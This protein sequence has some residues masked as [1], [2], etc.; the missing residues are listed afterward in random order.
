MF[1]WRLTVHRR[2]LKMKAKN[3][4][5]P[6][7]KCFFSRSFCNWMSLSSTSLMCSDSH[8]IWN[9]LSNCAKFRNKKKGNGAVIEQKKCV[10]HWKLNATIAKEYFF[11]DFDTILSIHLSHPHVLKIIFVLVCRSI[12]HLCVREQSERPDCILS[13]GNFYYYEF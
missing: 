4:D 7:L 8:R 6:P 9:M 13:T 12:R 3:Y 1:Q 5:L 11:T 2:F 10:G